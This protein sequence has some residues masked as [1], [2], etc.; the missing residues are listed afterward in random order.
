MPAPPTQCLSPPLPTLPTPRPVPIQTFPVLLADWPLLCAAPQG[1]LGQRVRALE[2]ECLGVK[3]G[4]ITL[5]EVS[6]KKPSHLHGPRPLLCKMGIVCPPHM[7]M[8]DTLSLDH[9]AK[10]LHQ[11]G[12]VLIIKPL[13]CVS[14]QS[15]VL[16]YIAFDLHSNTTRWVLIHTFS[17]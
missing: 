4:S 9:R 13:L 3:C 8:L 10:A 16:D 12:E 5:H 14:H 17:R 11:D 1:E 7:I 2:S 6:L 15:I